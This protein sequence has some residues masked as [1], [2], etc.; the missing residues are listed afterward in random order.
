MVQYGAVWCSKVHPGG[1]IFEEAGSLLSWPKSAVKCSMV[2][3][4][5]AVW[6][7][8]VVIVNELGVGRGVQAGSCFC[9]TIELL[10]SFLYFHHPHLSL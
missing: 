6:C 8:K 9:A 3:K 4:E 1:S 5:S 10:F 2:Q 7:S